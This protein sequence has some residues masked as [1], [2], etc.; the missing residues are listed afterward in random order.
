MKSYLT[1]L[2]VIL[3]LAQSGSGKAQDQQQKIDSLIVLFK[4][5]RHDWGTYAKQFIKIGDP[6]IPA[7][8]EMLEDK[9]LSQ[10]QR[11]IAAM[12]LNDINSPLYIETALKLFL[13]RNE[14]LTLRNSI[15]NAFKGHDLSFA[16]PD[17]WKVYTEESD[18]WWFRSNIAGILSAHDT[19]L[20][21][22]AY[23]EIYNANDGHLMRSALLNMVRLRPAESTSWFLIGLQ[24]GD[25]MTA[26]L[27]MDSLVLTRYI[28]PAELVNLYKLSG[29]PE[30]VRWRITYIFGNRELSES[31]PLLVDALQDPSW[32]ISNE[33][34][35]GLSRMASE[36]VL[37]EIED[38]LK[39]DDPRVVKD[40]KWVKKQLKV[41][42]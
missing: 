41:N 24:T 38:L 19:A 33:A 18:E 32:L 37:P 35:V 4:E 22:Q 30:E 21:Y 12:T 15:T 13:D 36:M 25:W 39:N 6:A 8:V 10:W 1:I 34:T 14:D 20:A 5:S 27:G 23:N 2:I 28:I 40:A 11:R 29:T 31:L 17:I 26:N 42:R 16:I 3:L 7:L 9:S